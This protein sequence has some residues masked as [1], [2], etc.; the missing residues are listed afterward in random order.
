VSNYPAYG[1][2]HVVSP[3]TRSA[4]AE[5]EIAHGSNSGDRLSA[6]ADEDLK[7]ALLIRH[8]ELK[9][10]D[11]FGQGQIN[12]TT[13]TCLGQEYVP[14]A[15]RPLLDLK[16]FVFSNHRGH[17]H[18]IARYGDPRGLLA[19]IMGREGA[20]CGGVGG[21]Q[22]ILRDRY[23]STGVQ[24]QSLPVATGMAL[25]LK[26]TS[27]GNMACA[28]IG[29][30]TWGEGAVYEALNMAQLWRLPL[31]VV[32]E[33]N[34]I[35]QSTATEVQMAGTIEGRCNGFGVQYEGVRSADINK[36]RNQ[37]NPCFLSIRKFAHPLVIEF[38]TS[39]VGPHSKGDDTRPA[40]TIEDVRRRDWLHR[41]S[42]E[43]AVQFARFDSGVQ[44]QIDDIAEQVAALP[45]ASLETDENFTES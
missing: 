34:G 44:A 5:T 29:D 7:L 36:I 25:A 37:L 32:V 10:L 24:G 9:L 14:V 18:Y 12:G 6:L 4:G 27:P 35:A 2:K 26:R 1:P 15:L 3:S 21:S 31:V 33:N 28:Y 43:F 40:E 41:Y 22:H 11:L 19:E 30:G 17:G 42:I 39:R 38:Q 20:V 13:H 16:D 23:L 8:F 45:L